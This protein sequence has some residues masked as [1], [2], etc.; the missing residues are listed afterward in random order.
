VTTPVLPS[1][2]IRSPSESSVSPTRSF[3]A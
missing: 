2:A 1:I 3:F